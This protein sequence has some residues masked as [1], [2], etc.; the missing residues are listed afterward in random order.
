MTEDATELVITERIEAVPVILTEQVKESVN[1]AVMYKCAII[2]CTKEFTEVECPFIFDIVTFSHQRAKVVGVDV[3]GRQRDIWIGH[4]WVVNLPSLLCLLLHDVI[5][6]E[7]VAL[8]VIIKQIIGCARQ[9][10]FLCSWLFQLFDDAL[11]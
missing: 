11:S 8:V 2:L 7:D 5:P 1:I 4:V 10:Q 9:L 3:D 6:G